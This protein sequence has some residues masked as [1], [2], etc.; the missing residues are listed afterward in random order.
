MNNLECRWNNPRWNWLIQTFVVYTLYF[1]T[2]LISDLVT[3]HLHF[4][5]V[6][7]KK[8]TTFPIYFIAAAVVCN[9]GLLFYHFLSFSCGWVPRMTANL[10]HEKERTSK[11][12]IRFS[13]SFLLTCF[14]PH[15]ICTPRTDAA[16]CACLVHCLLKW[17]WFWSFQ[18]P[19]FTLP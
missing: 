4:L 11:Q 14:W 15:D 10:S 1:F 13:C 12:K 17:Q 7:Q 6:K 5:Y 3:T 16:M 9:Y 8:P 18:R 19:L 2:P